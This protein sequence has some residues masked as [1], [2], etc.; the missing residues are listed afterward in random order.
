MI[1]DKKDLQA[2]EFAIENASISGELPSQSVVEITQRIGIFL[3]KYFEDYN[4]CFCKRIKESYKIKLLY[5]GELDD[6]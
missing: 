5:T 1:Y 3:D 6:L 2:L 4:K